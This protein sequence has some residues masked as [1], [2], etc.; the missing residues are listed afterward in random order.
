MRLTVTNSQPSGS[1][2]V[3]LCSQSNS[4]RSGQSDSQSMS[5]CEPLIYK[6]QPTPRK[7]APPDT[8]QLLLKLPPASP[9]HNPEQEHTVEQTL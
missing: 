8:A 5:S 3:I 4:L 6:K 9:A 1:N 2:P 7:K